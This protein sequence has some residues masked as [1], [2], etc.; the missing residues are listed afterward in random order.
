LANERRGSA[1]VDP[2]ELK[3]RYLAVNFI[4]LALIAA[5]FL[6]AGVVEVIKRLLAPFHGFAGL[7]GPQAQLLKYLFVALAFGQ[8]FLIK[9]VQKILAGRG[10][11]FL[12]QAAVITFAL[13][14]AVAV[15]GLILF[16]LQGNPMDFYVFMLL[17]LFYF[18]LFFPKYRDWEA[19]LQAP[20]AAPKK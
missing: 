11:Q 3:K 9:A 2:L 4:G 19:Q 15:L 6:Y 8:F 12:P 14:E 17:S 13:C 10:V 16:L 18:W 7:E 1:P 5:V 20:G